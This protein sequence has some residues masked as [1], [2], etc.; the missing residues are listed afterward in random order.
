M[1][2]VKTAEPLVGSCF[3]AQHFPFMSKKKKK[4][5]LGP[6]FLKCASAADSCVREVDVSFQREIT[7]TKAPGS[8]QKSGVGFS[9]VIRPVLRP[10]PQTSSHSQLM[11]HRSGQFIR[12]KEV[13]S[14]DPESLT[15]ILYVY[16]SQSVFYS[17]QEAERASVCTR[18]GM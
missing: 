2:W 15:N 7:Q 18:A 5:K 3:T 6:T 10:P 13:S 14:G 9:C 16:I 1:G 4:K 12:L 8:E 17:L 11:R